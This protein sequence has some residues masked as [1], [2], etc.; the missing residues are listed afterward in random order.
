VVA[1]YLTIADDG[2]V[3]R[4]GE[5]IEAG[6]PSG[7]PG[8]PERLRSAREVSGAR[9]AVT[10]GLASVGGEPCVL[11]GF[12]FSFLG[13]SM[14]VAEG[15]RIA[16]A[17]TVA[18]AH[19]VPVVSVAA[20]GGTR[21]QEGTSALAQ[22]QVIAAA[23]A[24]A[25]RAGIPHIAVAADPT[26]GGVWSSLVASADVVVGVPGARVSFSGSRTRP[27]GADRDAAA[28]RA[29]GGRASGSIDLLVPADRLRQELAAIIRLLS[30]RSRGNTEDAAA[31]VP[32]R[33]VAEGPVEPAAGGWAQVHRIRQPGSGQP[34]ADRWLAAY[35]E[36]DFA[37]SG[38]RCGG[39]DPAVRCG[40]GRRDGQT[41]GY[42]A[43]TGQA[44]TPAGFRTA[45]RLVELA[46]RFSVPV[47]TLIDT[48]GAAATP[49]DEAAGLGAAIAELFI[50][51]ASAQVPVT[52][53]VIG[54]GVSGGALAL[55]SAGNLWMAHDGYLAVTA[56]ELA[57]AILK[58]PPGDAPQLADLLRL[59]PEELLSR[60]IIRGIRRLRAPNR[61][62]KE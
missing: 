23:I 15:T 2:Q 30:P 17:F 43:Q 32:G 5:E 59:T 8:Y 44:T 3:E 49:D 46:T 21:M 16:R 58:R 51:I 12:D 53:V 4:F 37:I 27:A 52:S 36:Q 39:V 24:A 14:G 55:A 26:T 60:G 50:A 62:I 35:F 7:W 57:A 9:H 48:P 22:M 31:P 33:P 25:R 42:V 1:L 56:P 10:T 61:M 18:A 45:R 11:V 54:Q 28:Y 34:R 40:F 38:D 41:I 20:S 29:E 19:R 13:G 47:L 6:D